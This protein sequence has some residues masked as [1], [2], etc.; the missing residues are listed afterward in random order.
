MNMKRLHALLNAVKDLCFPTGVFCLIC[1][2]ACYNESLCPDCRAGM[3][4]L[5]LNITAD[6]DGKPLRLPGL[7][8]V[9]AVWVYE[10]LPKK[11]IWMLKFGRCENAAEVLASGI[12]EAA[13]DMGAFDAVTWIPMP[14]HRR[15]ERGIDHGRT[16]AEAVAKLLELPAVAALRLRD[17]YAATQR[18]RNAA[19]RRAQTNRFLAARTEPIGRMLL[20]DDVLTTGST[21]LDAAAA[22][23]R[24]GCGSVTAICA[25]QSILKGWN[26]DDEAMD[27]PVHDALAA[28]GLLPGER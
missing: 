6:A 1:N 23:Q 14:K 15:R 22:L 16:L 4:T 2:Q 5:R 19:E 8:A 26:A 3:D 28:A 20:V 24:G 27:Q 9:R 7:E 13:A 21:V 10:G 12:A 17:E 18:G 11:L 25:A